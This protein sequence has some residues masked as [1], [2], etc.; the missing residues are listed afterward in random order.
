MNSVTSVSAENGALPSNEADLQY[1]MRLHGLRQLKLSAPDTLQRM[2][3]LAG[4]VGLSKIII[5][6]VQH[7][8]LDLTPLSQLQQLRCLQL[9]DIQQHSNLQKLSQLSEAEV[10]YAA[11]TTALPCRRR[12]HDYTRSEHD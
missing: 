1:L 11:A 8:L 3:Q 5:S 6:N 12:I 2:P 4:L 7:E 9:H 10:L